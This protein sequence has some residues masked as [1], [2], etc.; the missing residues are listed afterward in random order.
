MNV[1]ADQLIRKTNLYRHSA[2]P[3]ALQRNIEVRLLENALFPKVYRMWV[4][5]DALHLAVVRSGMP[6]FSWHENTDGTRVLRVS[7]AKF[8]RLHGLVNPYLHQ[9]SCIFLPCQLDCVWSSIDKLN[10]ILFLIRYPTKGF[11]LFFYR[12]TSICKHFTLIFFDGFTVKI[13][14]I[15]FHWQLFSLTFHQYITT[16]DVHLVLYKCLLWIFFVKCQ[17][18]GP[19]WKV[20]GCLDLFVI[21]DWHDF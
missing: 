7:K 14:F 19:L 20:L 5:L 4:L 18:S 21:L 9:V 16:N 10:S 3:F 6:L 11:Y 8:T 13:T 17:I 15:L 12:G 2:D 1:L